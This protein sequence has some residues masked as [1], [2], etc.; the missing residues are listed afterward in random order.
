VDASGNAILSPWREGPE[1]F[2]AQQTGQLFELGV[3]EGDILVAVDGRD[4]RLGPGQPVPEGWLSGPIGS[5]V[6]VTVRTGNAPSRT[7][8]FI[9]GGTDAAALAPLGISLDFVRGFSLVTEVAFAAVFL[10]LGSLIFLRRSDDWLALLV[11]A[12]LIVVFLGTSSPVIALYRGEWQLQPLLDLW[13]SIALLALLAFLYLFPDGRFFPRATLGL[14]V[15]LAGAAAVASLAPVLYPWRMPPV[16]DFLVVGT[17]ISSGV[18]A[19]IVRYRHNS[20]PVERQQTRWVLFG[21]T[22]AMIGVVAKFWLQVVNWPPPSVLIMTI[23]NLAIYPLALL[24]EI[25]LPVSILLAV[26]RRKLFDI[27]TLINRALVYGLLST[28]VFAIYV[29]V[30]STLGLFLQTGANLL[31]SLPATVVV[32]ILFQP[33]RQRLQ[34]AV[35]RLMYGERDEPYMVIARLGRR[36]VAAFQPAATL[37]AIVE[38]VAWALKLPYVAITLHQD[39]E[40]YIVAQYG[41]VQTGLLRLP[42]V[43]A[44]EKFGELLLAPRSPGEPFTS[45][46]RRLLE[47]LARQA[48]VAANAVRLHW[49]LERSRQRIVLAREEARRKLGSYLHD[50]LGHRLAGLLRREDLVANTIRQDPAEAEALLLELRE[51]TRAT[52]DNV[53][54]LAHSLH[55][56]ELELLGLPD[57]LRERAAELS[58]TGAS[59]LQITVDVPPTLPA[60]PTALEVAVYYIAQEALTNTVR[61]SGASHASLHLRVKDVR[62]SEASVLEMRNDR[63]VELEIRDD[64]K[65]LQGRH[66]EV[67]ADGIGLLS[68]K[69]RAAELGGICVVETPPG[70]GTRVYA[71]IPWPAEQAET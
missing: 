65:G 21:T 35:N 9:R 30:V 22:A 10:I 47:D 42:L 26:L 4:V 63:A 7:Y 46:D 31:V 60:L 58:G 68:M 51:Q 20:G 17:L 27:D 33:L 48:G 1:P 70:G 41:T 53:R 34:R 28:I 18:A 23:Y 57:A 55:P 71:S 61:H 67:G 25:L 8:T 5:Q 45:G 3:L 32:A 54:A 36:L 19:Q 44:G 52:I 49:D 11:S 69:Q 16:A 39:N 40:Q 37:P 24:L 66:A 12:A 14:T 50:G 15:L 13:F 2:G 59:G 43:Y 38:T 62:A 29:A 64:G 6:T 56:P